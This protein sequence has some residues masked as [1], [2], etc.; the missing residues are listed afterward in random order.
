MDG[1]EVGGVSKEV[2]PPYLHDFT[3][4]TDEKGRFKIDVPPGNYLVAANLD[5]PPSP[6]FPFVATYSASSTGRAQA[7]QFGVKDWQTISADI[8]LPARLAQRK[9][10]IRVVWPNGSVVEDANV[11]L[12]EEK[13]PGRVVGNSVSHT[14]ADGNFDLIGFK[15][16]GYI[17]HANIYLPP[18]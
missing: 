16:I 5:S 18:R 12:A 7:K 6:E 3:K 14:G 2:V 17:I 9:I 15:G 8:R 10:P 1:I 4:R 13:R 11:W